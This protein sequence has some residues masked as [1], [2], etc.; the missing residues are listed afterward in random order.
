M[1]IAWRSWNHQSNSITTSRQKA[2]Q[3]LSSLINRTHTI[4]RP[5]SRTTQYQERAGRQANKQHEEGKSSFN[6]KGS[7]ESAC[8]PPHR[9]A[10]NKLEGAF[11]GARYDWRPSHLPS[12]CIC[13]HQFTVEHSLICSR[14]GFPSIRHNELRNI[15][16]GFLTEVCHNEPPLQPLSGEQ[17]T[18]RTA[19]SEDGAR[20]D[21]ATDNFWEEVGT[22]H[23]LT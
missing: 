13:G 4:K 7:L 17:L 23:F 8:H 22:A 18:L 16:A 11:R 15:M 20:L 1:V 6:R 9:F 5:K 12:H 3:L 19:N 21:V 10:L 2:S 14:G